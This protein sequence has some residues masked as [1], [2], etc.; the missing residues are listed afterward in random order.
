DVL[1]R[2]KV[3]VK[4]VEGLTVRLRD[5]KLTAAGSAIPEVDAVLAR[6]PDATVHRCFDVAER[7]LDENKESG[8]RISGKELADLNNFYIFTFETPSQRGVDLTNELLALDVVE[9]AYL[10]AN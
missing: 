6:Y 3:I 9:V 1:Q 2:D 5:G 7:I 8:E 4:F 10:Q